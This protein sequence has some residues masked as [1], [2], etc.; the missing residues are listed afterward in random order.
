[1]PRLWA[2]PL[3]L[4]DT[5]DSFIVNF[6]GGSLFAGEVINIDYSFVTLCLGVGLGNNFTIRHL[7][8]KVGAVS[9]VLIYILLVI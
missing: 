2:L 3:C 9:P 4:L 8:V 5:V 7:N 6:V 1:L